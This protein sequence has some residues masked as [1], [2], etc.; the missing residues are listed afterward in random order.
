MSTPDKVVDVT[1]DPA[2]L[3]N[4]APGTGNLPERLEHFHDLALGMFIHWGLDCLLGTVPSHWMI[5][6]DP[7]LV[8]RFIHE[9]PGHFAPGDFDAHRIARLARQAGMR[10]GCFTTKHHSGFCMFDTATTD[11]NVM[12]TPHARDVVRQYMEAFREVGVPPGLYFSPLDFLWCHQRKKLLHFMTPDVVPAGNP[13]LMGYNLAQM[14]ELLSNY[15]PIEM[16]FLDGPPEQLR[17]LAWQLQPEIVV[18]RGAMETPEQHLPDTA[19]PGV[20]EACCTIGDG[21][22]YKPTNDTVKSGTDLIEMLIRTRA[23]GGNLLLNITPDT[24]GRIPLE[25][26]RV[27]QELGT[28]LFFNGE[29]IYKV[30]PWKVQRDDNIWYTQSK[31]GQTVYAFVTGEPWPHG[32]FGRKTVILPSVVTTE[33]STVAMV[34][35]NGL[36]LEHSPEADTETRWQQHED[37]LHIDALRTY[38]PYDNRR[39]PNPVAFRITHAGVANGR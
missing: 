30:R 22:S 7:R 15:G 19:L 4:V 36:A 20:W 27:L 9:T 38:R 37:G 1:I 10:Y 16:L 18:T 29:A 35:Q 5:G 34:G 6:A 2:S 33:R 31:D 32:H 13:D 11:F 24:E 28:W 21:W 23:L 3:A 26:E 12:R 17:E 25:Q 39:W 14:R 8:D